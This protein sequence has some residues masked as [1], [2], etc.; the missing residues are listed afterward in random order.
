M[1]MPVGFMIDF[2]EIFNNLLDVMFCCGC[3]DYYPAVR[4]PAG[5][6]TCVRLCVFIMIPVT[7]HSRE[8]SECTLNFVGNGFALYWGSGM[9]YADA[10]QGI[11]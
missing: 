9:C 6:L 10:L 1:T 4:V 5:V 3:A 8:S 11:K 2:Q 7:K